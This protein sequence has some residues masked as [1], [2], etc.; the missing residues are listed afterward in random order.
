MYI[1]TTKTSIVMKRIYFLLIFSFLISE[2]IAQTISNGLYFM[3]KKDISLSV[4]AFEFYGTNTFSYVHVTPMSCHFGKGTYEIT[5]KDSLILTFEDF[6]TSSFYT[7]YKLH[8]EP[9]DSF[10]IDITILDDI[11]KPVVFASCNIKGENEEFKTDFNGRIKKNLKTLTTNSIL[12]INHSLFKTKEIPIPKEASKISGTIAFNYWN[13]FPKGHSIQLKIIQLKKS[14]FII[15]RLNSTKTFFKVN[16][17][18]MTRK[19]KKHMPYFY[20]HYY[21]ILF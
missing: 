4:E 21:H 7:D 12:E 6:D 10:F 20:E 17:Q 9:S 18:K 16:K 15:G 1:Y 13:T 3:Q 19:V 8:N 2:T 11:G 14:R 5:A